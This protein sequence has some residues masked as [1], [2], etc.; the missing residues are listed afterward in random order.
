MTDKCKRCAVKTA[1][2]ES[3]I[4]RM[5]DEVSAMRGVR[6]IDEDA[7]KKRLGVCGECEKLLYGTT[8]SAC[9]CVVRVRALLADGRCPKKK[10]G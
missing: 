9:G 1:L 7:Y 3:D 2:S 5:I 10:W 4:Q 6:L 8:C